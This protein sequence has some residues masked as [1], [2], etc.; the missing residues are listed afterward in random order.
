[1]DGLQ[2]EVGAVRADDDGLSAA[3]AQS[4]V[5]LAELGEKLSALRRHLNQVVADLNAPPD[6]ER[7]LRCRECGRV[8]SKD[9]SGWTLRL[10]GDDEL[11]TCCPD[12][13]R[14]LSGNGA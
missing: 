10:G 8:G 9:E 5:T 4:A 6:D 14:Y 11:H 2:R 1:V 3:T 12:C 7:R 13:D